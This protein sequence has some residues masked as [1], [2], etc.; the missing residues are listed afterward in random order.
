MTLI[1][2]IEIELATSTATLPTYGSDLAAGM[3]L[4]ADLDGNKEMTLYGGQRQLISSG[5]RIC[6]PEGHYGRVAP[7]SG[8]AYKNGIDVLAGVIDADYAGKVGVILLNTSSVPF[9]VHHG[10][11]I[12]QLIVERAS[13]PKIVQVSD[14]VV[15][16]DTARGEGGFGSTGT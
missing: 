5:V 7:R 1:C 4:Y 13:R 10:D 12:A 2:Q 15:N 11:R 14:G 3:D 9:T 16:S 6:L 8:L